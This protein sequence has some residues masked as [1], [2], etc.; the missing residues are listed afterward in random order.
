[1]A[2]P[3]CDTVASF[4]LAK[5]IDVVFGI[6]G[7]ANSRLYQSFVKA[8]M[9]IYNVHNEQAA[10]QAA[11]AY[12]QTCGKLAAVTITSGG[13]VTNT[14]TG[15][16]SLWADSIPTIIL[17]GQEA[18]HCVNAHLHRR[19]YGIQGFDVVTMVSK[20]TKY[21]KIV[22]NVDTLRDDL[23]SAYSACMDRRKGPVWLDIPVD[24]QSKT[25][26]V[27]PWRT[28]SPPEISS[29]I[30]HVIQMLDDAKRPIIL[31]GHG[32]KL[33]NSV[34]AFKSMIERV[35]VPVIASWSAIDV[36][37]HNHPLYFG[38]AG[39]YAQRSSNFIFQK[40]D[41]ILVLGSRISTPQSGYD[42][43]E[44][45]RCAKI[46]MVDIDETEFKSFAHTHVLSDCGKFI[47]KMENVRC[48]RDEWVSECRAIRTEF[49]LVE[50][51]AHADEEFP[52]SYKIIDKISDYLT[53]KHVIVTDMGTALLS[54][55]ST[56]R[57]KEGAK[58]FSSYGLGEMGYGLPA[59]FGAAIAA[60]DR[61]VLCLN[62]DGGMMMNLQELQ[63]IVQHGLNVKIVIF[64]NDGYLM[65]KHTQKLLFNGTVTAADSKTGIVLPDYMKVADAFGYEKYRLKSWDDFNSHFKT[66]MES[67]K[68]AICEIFMP[69]EQDFVPK[70]KGLLLDDG[71]F[72][73]PPLEEMSPLLPYETVQRIMGDSISKKSE[74]I[75]RP[76][77]QQ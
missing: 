48:D 33:S 22:L 45:G 19:M 21:A 66:F 50:E 57:L 18:S 26:P 68:P 32:I 69:P 63:T 27:A 46:V 58:M 41:L 71:S 14:I 12:Y 53:E 76:S 77:V 37:G 5:N 61:Q 60:P 34:E 13:G 11:G 56:I 40:A 35:R 2:V 74:I 67:D 47:E 38:S 31:A 16:T 72:F 4:L 65:M 59:A 43:K 42:L 28:Y 29:D 24:I 36:L 9:T 75:K 6:I 54:G 1:M 8:G 3:A 20:I 51:P 17:S 7:G 30:S 55:H 64:N 10:V 44:F 23:E 25:V 70:V 73:A 52:N 39:I 62:C 49:P 15:V